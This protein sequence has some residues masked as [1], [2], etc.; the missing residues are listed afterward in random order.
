MS[1]CIY[2]NQDKCKSCQ[3]IEQT[4]QNQLILKQTLIEEK[5][6]SFEP[7]KILSVFESKPFGF[8]NKAKMGVYGTVDYPI[9]GIINHKK[10]PVSLTKCPLYSNSMQDILEYLEKWIKIAH[11]LPYQL[12][13]K[14][15]ELKFILVTQSN[16]GE[17]MVRF[18]LKSTKMKERIEKHLSLL[19]QR[20]KQIK[21]I[22][23]NIQPIHMAII[24]GEEEIF[25]TKNQTLKTYL[26]EI[27]LYIKPKSFFQTN[28]R[29][30]EGLYKNAKIWTEKLNIKTG[31]DLFCGVGG[32]A[33]S[34]IEENQS[35]IGV[36]IEQEAI[37]CA[38]LS[39]NELNIKGLSFMALDSLS[40]SQKDYK[41]PDII[42]VNPPR[43]GLKKDLAISLN[44][45]GSKHILYSSCNIDSFVEDMKYLDNYKIKKAQLFDMFA[46][47]NHYEVL[48]LLDINLS[49]MN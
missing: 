24:E 9:L 41:V 27:P 12:R 11:I 26:N 29:V 16:E 10:E 6:S 46:N 48:I 21:V 22:S 36:E 17:F 38:N 32:F 34:C 5:L 43:R 35:F 2:Y 4:Y 30:A 8:R 23:L 49:C 47:T 18:V 45:F 31:W 40:F 13:T 3:L 15:G 19:L 37:N 7:Q 1:Q 14:K 44:S 33:L 25:L 42:I 20:F 39:A 28:T